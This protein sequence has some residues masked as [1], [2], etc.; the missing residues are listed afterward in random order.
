MVKID[1]YNIIVYANL[2]ISYLKIFFIVCL[3]PPTIFAQPITF[4]IIKTRYENSVSASQVITINM[5]IDPVTRDV[6]ICTVREIK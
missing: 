5:A 3:R 1:R 2:A 6:L 4:A